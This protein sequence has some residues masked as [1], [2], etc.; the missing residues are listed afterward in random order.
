M[1]EDHQYPANLI[2]I[3]NNAQENDD[4]IK[5]SS[6]NDVWFHLSNLPSCHVVIQQSKKHKVTKE[7]IL[8]CAELVKLNTKYKNYNRLQVDYT[9]IK[10]ITRTKTPGTVTFKSRNRVNTI[11]V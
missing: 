11:T 4:L 6:Q 7:M 9:E 8:Y 1:I 5:I 10:N 2:R 3:G